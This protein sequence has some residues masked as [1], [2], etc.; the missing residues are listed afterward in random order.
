MTTFA[1]EP[2]W[3]LF[4]L[5]AHA[6]FVSCFNVPS[7]NFSLDTVNRVVALGSALRDTV[8][9]EGDPQVPVAEL[10]PPTPDDERGPRPA[11]IVRHLARRVEIDVD[12][13]CAGWLVLTDADYPGW[14]ARVDGV[15]TPIRR[16]NALFRAV[17]V[18]PGGHRVE[19]DYDPVSARFG[20]FT[21]LAFLGY[22]LVPWLTRR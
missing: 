22:C 5:A 1:G 7:L 19:F 3:R 17:H 4:S 13:P 11:R 21:G 14:R 16:A 10:R 6:A 8:V 12:A 18:G 2:M 15:A 20:L 9:L